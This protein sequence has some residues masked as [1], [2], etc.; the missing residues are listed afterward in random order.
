LR[1]RGK[2]LT[3]IVSARIAID[4]IDLEPEQDA[5]S[6]VGRLDRRLAHDHALPPL[7]KLQHQL[8]RDD[9]TFVVRAAMR[10]GI[11]KQPLIPP[12]ARFNITDRSMVGDAYEI[13]MRSYRTDAV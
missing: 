10:A 13:L 3:F 11:I 5:I 2:S 4:I 9:Q 7:M 8:A 1:R 6:G 12:A